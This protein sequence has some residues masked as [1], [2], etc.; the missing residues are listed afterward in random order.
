MSVHPSSSIQPSLF[1][2]VPWKAGT[3]NSLWY[4]IIRP[5]VSV[6]VLFSVLRPDSEIGCRP[7]RSMK[8]THWVAVLGVVVSQWLKSVSLTVQS[9][10]AEEAAD[11]NQSDR[12]W[13]N[14]TLFLTI[15]LSLTLYSSWTKFSLCRTLLSF[16]SFSFES[17]RCSPSHHPRRCAYFPDLKWRGHWLYEQD[18]WTA[19]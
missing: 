2:S 7:C 11:G 5:T 3:H 4:T 17:G 19:R 8:S 9:D 16:T 12:L 13:S 10:W 18:V 14:R 15:S 1:K 6:R